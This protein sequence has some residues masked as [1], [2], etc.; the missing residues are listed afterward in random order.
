[1]FIIKKI[2]VLFLFFLTITAGFSA[3]SSLAS[4]NNLTSQA[5]LMDQV[6]YLIQQDAE[7]L[8]YDEV[9]RLSNKIIPNRSKYPKEVIAKIYL[10]LANIALNKGEME[11]AFQFTQDGLVAASLHQKTQLCLQIKLAEILTAKKQYK[12]LLSVSEN[13]I[14]ALGA[15][16]NTKYMLFA[17]SYRSV[18]NAMLFKHNKAL[19]DLQKVQAVIEQN[20]AFSEHISLLSIL[21]NAYY[22]LGE[23][24][25]SLTIQLKILKLRFTLNRLDNVN[26]TYNHL[27]NAYLNLH[28]YNDAYNA[29]WEAKRY[30]EKK[31]APIY[32][33]Y[34]GQGM[35]LALQHQKQYLQAQTELVKAQKIFHQHNLAT[36]YLETLITLAQISHEIKQFPAKEAY[37]LAAEK[38]A[39]DNQLTDQYIILYQLLAHMYLTK[40][41][42]KK[43]Y[44]WQEKYSQALLDTKP[45]KLDA[46]AHSTQKKDLVD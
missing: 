30:A 39:E 6:E 45:L 5:Q 24:Q 8:H 1:M 43:A 12:K 31:A 33:A 34:A 13:T 22:Y 23:Y 20:P 28:R 46:R 7:S 38:R 42:V 35:A 14:K 4:E 26:Q 3:F 29:Y 44:F 15:E 11:S 41:E 32:A 40:N 21:A 36:P 19:E 18:A 17:L 2:F 27:G 16:D 9:I 25:T 37:L 10:L